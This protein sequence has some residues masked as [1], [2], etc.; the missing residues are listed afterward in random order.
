LVKCSVIYRTGT[1]V[2]IMELLLPGLVARCLDV[3][4]LLGSQN[5]RDATQAL[6][7]VWWRFRRFRVS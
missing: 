3:S 6:Q 5:P 2:G 7:V 1:A 4:D